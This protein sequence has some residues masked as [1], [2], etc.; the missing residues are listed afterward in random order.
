MSRRRRP[1]N[2]EV[3]RRL[4][5]SASGSAW[6]SAPTRRR[7]HGNLHLNHPAQQVGG[8]AGWPSGRGD[9]PVADG[10]RPAGHGPD[11]AGGPPG[12]WGARDARLAGADGELRGRPAARP[13]GF[14]ARR[15]AARALV[16]S[17][18]GG[19]ASETGPRPMA[20]APPERAGPRGP[21]GPCCGPALGA[22]EDRDGPAV[23]PANRGMRIAPGRG[24]RDPGQPRC[25]AALGDTRGRAGLCPMSPPSWGPRRPP[26][27][28]SAWNGS[29]GRRPPSRSLPGHHARPL[30]ERSPGCWLLVDDCSKTPGRVDDRSLLHPGWGP[31]EGPGAASAPWCCLPPPRPPEERNAQIGRRPGPVWPGGG[32]MSAPPTG[33]PTRLANWP[34]DR[35]WHLVDLGRPQSMEQNPRPTPLRFVVEVLRAAVAS[36]RPPVAPKHRLLTAPVGQAPWSK[37]KKRRAGLPPGGGPPASVR[38]GG[39]LRAR[40]L[41]TAGSRRECSNPGPRD[42]ASKLVRENSGAGKAPALPLARQPGP[43][44]QFANDLIRRKFLVR[45]NARAAR[46]WPTTAGPPKPLLTAQGRSRWG[47]PRPPGRR[48]PADLAT[49]STRPLACRPPARTPHGSGTAGQRT[50]PQLATPWPPRGRRTAWLNTE[51]VPLPPAPEVGSLRASPAT[52]P[53]PEP[54]R[55]PRSG[56]PEP[57]GRRR[58]ARKRSAIPPGSEMHALREKLGRRVPGL[59][60]GLPHQL[61]T[62]AHLASLPAPR[63]NPWVEPG[64]SKPNM[65][66]PPLGVS[67]KP[68]PALHLGPWPGYVRTAVAA[69]RA[70]ADDAGPGRAGLDWLEESPMPSA[71]GQYPLAPGTGPCSPELNAVLRRQGD[72][73][74]AAPGRKFEKPR[75]LGVRRRPTGIGPFPPPIEEGLPS[76]PQT[77]RP[78]YPPSWVVVRLVYPCPTRAGSAR[79]CARFPPEPRTPITPWPPGPLGAF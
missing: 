32:S 34:S 42:R 37:K 55:L 65:P 77:T 60:A 53:G 12:P 49:G 64:P 14:R 61:T 59:H 19:R 17:S 1:A 30:A 79:P 47:R 33:T 48:S 78:G 73:V 9:S 38:R 29:G 44:T 76:T 45:T 43:T 40:R 28:G 35:P 2:R 20:L 58:K 18:A 15:R 7:R 56:R 36:R 13:R 27:C 25:A 46:P 51:L 5:R 67:S 74:P 66:L 63:R 75:F 4:Q 10:W 24:P 52:R 39:A 72:P 41:P 70:A 31:R 3:A 71:P 26:P 21:A 8:R 62:P 22:N 23:P 16:R 57:G 68:S 11:A 54:P 69:G 6:N 50:R